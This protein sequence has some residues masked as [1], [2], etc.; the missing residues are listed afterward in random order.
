MKKEKFYFGSKAGQQRTAWTRVN[1][2]LQRVAAFLSICVC[3]TFAGANDLFGQANAWLTNGKPYIIATT[4]Q[5]QDFAAYVNGGQSMANDTVFLGADITMTGANN[6]TTPIGNTTGNAFKGMFEGNGYTIS[7]LSNNSST[8]TVSNNVGLFGFVGQGGVVRNI[9]LRG[10]NINVGTA[11][12]FGVTVAAVVANLEGGTLFRCYVVNSQVVGVNNVGGVVGRVSGGGK[13]EQCYNTTDTGAGVTDPNRRV[14]TKGQQPGGNRAGGVV[15]VVE[16]AG[17]WIE[18]C[19]N[20]VPVTANIAGGVVAYV[21]NAN[22]TANRHTVTS[23]YNTGLIEAHRIGDGGFLAGGVVGYLGNYNVLTNSFNYSNVRGGYGGG[24]TQPNYNASGSVVG[25]LARNTT[26]Q[27]ADSASATGYSYSQTVEWGSIWAIGNDQTYPTASGKVALLEPSQMTGYSALENMP[28][29]DEN[30]FEETNNS[31]PRLKAYSEGAD[32]SGSIRWPF[33]SK[34]YN[35]DEQ[36]P[37]GNPSIYG[38]T[39]PTGA[40]TITYTANPQTAGHYPQLGTAGEPWYAG[41]YTVTVSYN[42]PG[43]RVGTATFQFAITKA[44]ITMPTQVIL[45]GDPYPGSGGWVEL[46]SKAYDGTTAVNIVGLLFNGLLNGDQLNRINTNEPIDFT[47]SANLNTVN[48]GGG[49]AAST[50]TITASLYDTPMAN[51][52]TLSG[53]T[54]DQNVPSNLLQ[55]KIP[56]AA[57]FRLNKNLWVYNCQ[58]FGPAPTYTGDNDVHATVDITP[59]LAGMG[60]ITAHYF[61]AG[62]LSSVRNVDSYD[63]YIDVAAGE[64]YAAVN[65]LKVGTFTI[66]R[67][68]ISDVTWPTITKVYNG[69]MT[70]P[71]PLT[72]L[73]SS[74]ICDVGVTLSVWNG[75][76]HS[77][78]AGNGIQ[79]TYGNISVGGSG[80]ANY[81]IDP[82]LAGNLITTGDITP[83]TQTLTAQQNPVHLT[84]SNFITLWDDLQKTSSYATS[85]ATGAIL[86]FTPDLSG[87]AAGDV[88]YDGTTYTLSAVSIPSGGYTIPVTVTSAA[89]NDEN[90]VDAYPE[91]AAALSITFN[92]EVSNRTEHVDGQSGI[93]LTPVTVTYDGLGHPFAQS[94]ITIDPTSVLGQAGSAAAG[95]I[96]TYTP[97]TPNALLNGSGEPLNA[98]VYRVD[99]YYDTNTDEFRNWTT[100]TI[101]QRAISATEV[102]GTL[103]AGPYVYTGDEI[104]PTVASVSDG[105][106]TI[107]TLVVYNAGA[108]T[109]DYSY[110]QH[111]YNVNAG[112][113]YVRILGHGNYTG[114]KDIPFTIEP[115]CIYDSDVNIYITTGYIYTGSQIVPEVAVEY[116]QRNWVK[117]TDFT[118]SVASGDDVNAG[119]FTIEV[120]GIGNFTSSCTGSK[121][122]TITIH[123]A[124]IPEGTPE[125]TGTSSEKELYV[126]MEM[127]TTHK[128]RM[129]LDNILPATLVAAESDITGYTVQNINDSYLSLFNGNPYIQADNGVQTLFIPVNSVILDGS[130]RFEILV[131]SNNYEDHVIHVIVVPMSRTVVNIAL[132]YEGAKIYDA[133]PY[134]VPAI[135]LSVPNLSAQEANALPRT[136]MYTGTGNTSY[137][138]S[139][140]PPTH[141][142]AYT[143]NVRVN[144]ENYTGI[145]TVS[146]RI[147]PRRISIRIQDE[148]IQ[149]GAPLPAPRVVASNFIPETAGLITG[150]T[151]Q[152]T[153][154]TAY[155]SSRTGYFPIVFN[156]TPTIN[157]VHGDYL[158]SPY[159]GIL[160][161]RTIQDDCFLLGARNPAA[162]DM[163]YYADPSQHGGV[164]GGMTGYPTYAGM[165]DM[166][167]SPGATWKVYNDAACTQEVDRYYVPKEDEK[168]LYIKVWG[169]GNVCVGTFK[170]TLVRY[171]AS[172]PGGFLRRQV[173]LPKVTGAVT[174]PDWG[175]HYTNSFGRFTFTI[176]ALPGYASSHA[177][178]IKTGSAMYPDNSNVTVVKNVDGSYTITIHGVQE[179]LRPTITWDMDLSSGNDVTADAIR[180]W[181]ADGRLHIVWPQ[182]GEAHI[183]SVAG[184]LL[185]T[186]TCSAG[187]TT[188][189][190]NRGFY[191]VTLSS[192]KTFKVV[193]K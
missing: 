87:V 16:G 91:W 97:Q 163:V 142:G 109:G 54:T 143:M 56:T 101:T 176:A 118:V 119:T 82:N 67:K 98:G 182:G 108:G 137:S 170:L 162:Y 128:Y 53:S 6:W 154:H 10:A 102:T 46:S 150:G 31:V 130:S 173:I 120:A 26:T 84:E 133:Q 129:A 78:C 127:A 20:T 85:N 151:A 68:T 51:N 27:A 144:T 122:E 99:V 180:V 125:T 113:A 152:N 64:N 107:G 172:T 185:Q 96:I 4:A 92:V 187:E 156:T 155:S 73:G 72:G 77:A 184:Q 90:C 34:M 158:F 48:V 19:F 117:D 76:Y 83:A 70:A 25:F 29:L 50:V 41:T 12:N 179:D 42:E 60:T 104:L 55:P 157:D 5:L 33:V 145:N 159:E 81:E 189:P 40:W 45:A 80:Y 160:T 124:P 188:T 178:Q 138:S 153:H 161:V 28:L 1:R 17:G 93:G 59:P 39:N 9:T 86:V 66:S 181:S 58:S 62:R 36:V 115:K 112:Q 49:S 24:G 167:V 22:N 38:L 149:Q 114:N 168:I 192:G 71:S 37:N 69:N 106:N 171:V 30:V 134:A 8:G 140:T 35:S 94:N 186:L 47:A 126:R 169:Y 74:F 183:Y 103:S 43:V 166:I 100:I 63:V 23:C 89:V 131:Q 32:I 110:D 79:I 136:I 191:V 88:I 121:T 123:K 135:A 95:P 177:P 15:G 3:L 174:T 7:G 44:P 146:F 132:T 111:F 2:T 105:L 116:N 52:Y 147:L 18:A 61:G 11:P 193:V 65:N 190:V 139:P 175:I 21:S 164:H 14:A 148:T 141:V 165:L 75:T 57:D 13:V